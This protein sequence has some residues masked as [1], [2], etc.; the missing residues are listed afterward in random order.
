MLFFQ[1]YIQCILC[2]DIE[3]TYGNTTEPCACAEVTSVGKLGSAE[4]KVIS[5]VVFD[6]LAKLGIAGNR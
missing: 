3:M 6:L 1:Q 5:G 2:T 4:N